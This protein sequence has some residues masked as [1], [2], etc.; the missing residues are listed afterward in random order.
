M[1]AL[2]AVVCA[3]Y[4]NDL[5]R[6]EH[7]FYLVDN[8]QARSALVARSLAQGLGYK[9]P[10][11][12]NAMV[13]FY[14]QAGKLNVDGLWE[15]SDRFPLTI[16]GIF[17]LF[18]LLGTTSYIV[19][20]LLFGIVFFLA[21]AALVYK[22]AVHVTG[23]PIAGLLSVSLMCLLPDMTDTI[24]FK[25]ADDL[26]YALL[27]LYS[28]LIWRQAI[29]RGGWWQ[30]ILL[31]VFA[32]LA[33]LCRENMGLFFLAAV[34]VDGVWSLARREFT[35]LA[36]LKA[37]LLTTLGFGA[38]ILPFGWYTEQVWGVPFFSANSLYQFSFYSPYQ[39][40]TDAWWKLHTPVGH[41][42]NWDLFKSDPWPFLRNWSD[43]I[44]LNISGFALAYDF[45]WCLAIYAIARRWHIGA[46]GAVRPLLIC[47]GV[48]LL[49]NLFSLGF[50]VV[51]SYAPVYMLGFI[52][53]LIVLS[54][55]GVML[56]LPTVRRLVESL[57]EREQAPKPI[58]LVLSKRSAVF[59][60]R[61]QI[62]V[63]AGLLICILLYKHYTLVLLAIRQ[64]SSLQHLLFDSIRAIAVTGACLAA[65]FFIL[66]LAVSPRRPPRFAVWAFLA[67]VVASLMTPNLDIK[68]SAYI[69]LPEDTPSLQKLAA[70]TPPDGI[71]LAFNGFYGLPWLLDRK[72][73]GLPEY[74]DYIYEMITKYNLPIDTIYLD[75]AMSWFLAANAHNWAPSY[76]IY[77]ITGRIRG[78]IP[79]FEL[80]DYRVDSAGYSRYAFPSVPKEIAVYR[81]I[82]GF[83]FSQLT[84]PPVSYTADNPND[85]I[86]FI[87][88]FGETGTF[89]GR[90]VIFASD[91][92]RA[93]YRMRP[94]GW[95]PWA[96]N[97]ITF[98]ANAA[99]KPKAILID[100]YML[101]RTQMGI[102]L[103]L[104][105]DI[106]DKPR[107]RRSKQVGD[108]YIAEP[109]WQQ[110]RI[111]L[112]PDR[113]VDGL[114]KIGFKSTFFNPVSVCNT[115]ASAETLIQI[116]QLDRKKCFNING[117]ALPSGTLADQP[118]ADV[119]SDFGM[120]QRKV[121]Q[122]NGVMLVH[123][124]TFEY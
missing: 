78:V 4:L 95:E 47:T 123:K 77:P 99:R 97:D 118:P 56:F 113:V 83:D 10:L 48:P 6:P 50:F 23:K 49:L 106:Y 111:E 26:F 67:I 93:R 25:G 24:V 103:N 75:G 98:H 21:S 110:I 120:L 58:G 107:E 90:T 102:Y 115:D 62:A 53:L 63:M 29:Y 16:F 40:V 74:P 20:I 30:P 66:Q 14:H 37:G 82:P 60:Q 87:D 85:R 80:V 7:L 96:D 44:R 9:S 43:F 52:P 13:E 32:G 34:G 45:N 105:L 104:D 55:D 89:E 61:G 35:F 71:I 121:D 8:D 69:S 39:M 64:P 119:L 117:D 12:T 124:V 1:I 57:A 3:M 68:A 112:P 88:G 94:N 114:N 5:V 54:I 11:L 100:A 19:G 27:T 38:C 81:R 91:E 17:V 109:G 2:V 84:V 86:H 59:S 15:N 116:A 73:L 101:G 79:G 92:V 65:L 42:K 46:A 28:Y 70:A 36:G 76:E 33:F 51:A 108:L 31:G 22:L 41:I 18:K 72:V 122:A